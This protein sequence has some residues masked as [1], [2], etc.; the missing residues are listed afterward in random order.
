MT[1]N[2][3]MAQKAALGAGE[4]ARSS[5]PVQALAS[6]CARRFEEAMLDKAEVA[7]AREHEV[8]EEGY[9]EELARVGEALRYVDVLGRG[10]ETS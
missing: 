4:E 5:S 10:F 9:A 3:I 6:D 2:P 8:V 7:L 1:T